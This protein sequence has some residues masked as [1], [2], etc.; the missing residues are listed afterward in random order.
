MV[1]EFTVLFKQSSAASMFDVNLL[2]RSATLLFLE[3]ASAT[4]KVSW[5]GMLSD[6]AILCGLGLSVYI[7]N[8]LNL[9]GQYDLRLLFD[10]SIPL[11]SPVWEGYGPGE[12]IFSAAQCRDPEGLYA[13]KLSVKK[14]PAGKLRVFAMVTVWD[15]MVLKPIHDMCFSFL[16]ELPCDGTFDQHKSEVRARSKA[17]KWGGSFGYDLSAATDRLPV[18]IQGKILDMILPD[19]GANWSLLLTRREYFLYL[20][21]ELYPSYGIPR[22]N[23][24]SLA[25][26]ERGGKVPNVINFGGIDVPV[27]YNMQGKAYVTLTYSVGQPMGA[28]SS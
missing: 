10:A 11:A 19:L 1:R 13:G 8:I 3:T 17:V 26:L 2:Y 6:P 28:L 16:K 5:S 12:G 14:E 20:P 15:Q 21:A 27:F 24:E 18:S 4:Q 23:R 7:Q 25:L 22:N 9:L